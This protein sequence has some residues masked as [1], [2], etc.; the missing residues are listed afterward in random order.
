LQSSGEQEAKN[1]SHQL[2]YNHLLKKYWL[3]TLSGKTIET[4]NN[5]K[6]YASRNFEIKGHQ[7]EPKI[8][9]LFTKNASLDIFYEMQ[10][11]EN[12]LGSNESLKQ[13][14]F[15]TSF[16]IASEKKLTLN[17][18]FS[19]FDNK[20]VGDEFSPVAFQMLEGLQPGKNM[21]WRLLLQKNLTQYLD[22]NINYLGRKSETTQMVHTGNIQLRAYF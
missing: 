10:N 22:V 2:Q 18:E 11:K 6:N 20:F 9:Y 17:G 14:R 1:T 15:G 13:N 16:N 21:T 12:K 3:F 5:S 4:S 19:W 8:S 7:L